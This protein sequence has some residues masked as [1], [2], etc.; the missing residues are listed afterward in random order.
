MWKRKIIY[1]IVDILLIN[2]GF[3][4]SFII[5]FGLKIPYYNFSAYTS[6]ALVVTIIYIAS[7]YVFEV[8]DVKGQKAEDLFEALFQAV[9]FSTLLLIALAFIARKFSFP[10]SVILISFIINYVLL[11]FSK[12]LLSKIIPLFPNK[13]R[14]LIVGKRNDI[15]K[16][17]ER[18][19]SSELKRE[20]IV[21]CVVET[22][23]NNGDNVNCTILGEVKDIPHLIKEL[24]I[25][26]I[27]V[28]STSSYRTYTENLHNNAED[29]VRIDVLPGIYEILIGKLQFTTLG[30]VPLIRLT[31]NGPPPW[32]DP[33]KRIID[34]VASLFILII[35][36]PLSLLAII[37][38]KL[39]SKGPVIFKQKRVG[40]NGKLFTIYKFR[41]MVPNAEADT[42]AVL[43]AKNDPRT[44]RIGRILRRYRI[45][46][47][48]QLI[49]VIRG[50]MSFIGPRPE[51]P[52]FVERFKHQIENY[53]E[54]HSIKPG[55]T[56]LAQVY[57]G[58]DTPPDIK[59]K[60]DLFYI[61][62]RSF[63]LDLKILL[64]TV[65]TLF[66]GNGH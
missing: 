3:Y 57:G 37:A 34:V 9:G 63:T 36:F 30:D 47:I 18:V 10:R 12:V 60:Y 54:R 14:I 29:N 44:T 25:H 35:T 11:F 8:Y 26:R 16:F 28:V 40:K 48:P 4:F 62:N 23:G 13:E 5:R 66:F 41:T 27:V 20:E 59:L 19:K 31:R 1:Y 46:E 49:N 45:D 24:H 52:E 2:I 22:N 7:N 64:L 6:L 17:L 56:G 15:K 38:I 53:D 51:R 32:Y 33:L 21:G 55:I 58:Y 61:Y 65:R 43:A 50:E 42:G 39:D